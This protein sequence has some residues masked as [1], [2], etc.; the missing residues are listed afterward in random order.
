[1]QKRLRSFVVHA[2]L[3]LGGLLA[4]FGAFC[5]STVT[6]E[7]D[8][9]GFAGIN[10]HSVDSTSLRFSPSPGGDLQVMPEVGSH[11][12]L[13]TRGLAVFGTPD[14]SLIMEFATPATSLQLAFG[15]DDF[16]FTTAGDA[17][18]L[19]AFL[20]ERAVASA[21]VPL[22]RND[23]IDQTIA[24]SGTLF[25]R[26]TFF[27]TADRFLAET[28]DDITFSLLEG[29]PPAI[30]EPASAWL[31]AFGLAVLLWRKLA[32]DGRNGRAQA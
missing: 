5:A 22:N 1:M 19:V 30:P 4:T 16:S 18:V 20:G 9:L 32:R 6:F 10:F 29:A 31:L 28:V 24:I 27:Y 8:P 14:V 13:G 2:A 15:N 12:F 26:A 23:L 25:D 21:S 11:E 7:S 3:A 17:A